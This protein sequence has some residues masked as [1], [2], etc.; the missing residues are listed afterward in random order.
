MLPSC[1]APGTPVY[2]LPV[3][4]AAPAVIKPRQPAH[5]SA[6]GFGLNKPAR[7]S[8]PVSPSPVVP[9]QLRGSALRG[10]APTSQDND[11]YAR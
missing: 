6:P 1:A 9:P 4:P 3:L 7:G 2:T 5:G 8:V 10:S 11:R